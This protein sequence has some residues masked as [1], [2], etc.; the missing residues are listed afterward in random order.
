MPLVLYEDESINISTSFSIGDY[1][2]NSYTDSSSFGS[3]DVISNTRFDA[4]SG[5]MTYPHI[6][7]DT[8]PDYTNSFRFTISLSNTNGNEWLYADLLGLELDVHG[9]F[10]TTSYRIG[11]TYFDF[12]SYSSEKPLKAHYIAYGSDGSRLT[13]G[14]I[15]LNNI[16]ITDSN[17]LDFHLSIP[18]SLTVSDEPCSKLDIYFDYNIK[19]YPSASFDAIGCNIGFRVSDSYLFGGYIPSSS[20]GSSDDDYNQNVEAELGNIQI[21]INNVINSVVQMGNQA[22]QGA[23]QTVQAVTQMTTQLSNVIDQQRQDVLNGLGLLGDDISNTMTS[24]KNEITNVGSTISNKME[25]TTQTIVNTVE[26]KV[27]EVT[28]A[29][30]DVKDSILDLPNKISEMLISLVVPNEETMIAQ[31]EQ[32]EQLLSDRFGVVYESVAMVDSV[33]GAF[34]DNGTTSTITMPTVTVPVAGEDFVFGGY[35]VDV[36]PQGFSVLVEAL[37]LIIDI[38]VTLAFINAMKNR[39]EQLVSR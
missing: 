24:V 19:N 21:G 17:C 39:Y 2:L 27:D 38:V 18:R 20:T 22:W 30:E 14:D 33:V 25:E 4:S 13:S 8:L 12:F 26:T 28:T 3:F 29:V 6:S 10:L 16:S 32:W 37:K 5:Y 1:N 15:N 7:L 35:E 34:T 9:L 23:Q 36:V 31:K 11:S